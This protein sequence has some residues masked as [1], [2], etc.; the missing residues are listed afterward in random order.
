MGPYA[1]FP[2][3]VDGAGFEFRLHDPEVFFDFPAPLIDLH[4]VFRIPVYIGDNGIESVI[5]GFFGNP[6]FVQTVYIGLRDFSCLADGG[7][8][9]ESGGI[10]RILSP[11]FFA[12]RIENLLGPLY[13]TLPY[14]PLVCLVFR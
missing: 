5:L 14:G 9:N 8:L 10:V 11:S 3:D 6:S 7:F 12:G 13:L 2:A 4:N 1:V